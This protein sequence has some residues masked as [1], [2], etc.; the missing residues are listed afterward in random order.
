M[1]N[2]IAAEAG[3]SPNSITSSEASYVSEERGNETKLPP[4]DNSELCVPEPSSSKKL[5][6]LTNEGTSP[7]PWPRSSCSLR[8]VIFPPKAGKS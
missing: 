7:S 1:T 6:S 2:H 5:P 8:D 3:G 4:V